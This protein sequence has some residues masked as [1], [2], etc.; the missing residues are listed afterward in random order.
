MKTKIVGTVCKIQV[1]AG[2]GHFI[3]AGL[4][5]TRTKVV[6]SPPVL[7]ELFIGQEVIATVGLKSTDIRPEFRLIYVVPR[8]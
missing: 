6:A 2:S 4:G 8:S 7:S 1:A 3:L 5:N